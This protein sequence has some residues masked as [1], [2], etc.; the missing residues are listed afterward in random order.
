MTVRIAS[1]RKQRRYAVPKSHAACVEFEH[2][3]PNGQTYRLAITN[4]SASGLSFDVDEYAELQ[5]LEEGANVADATVRF[6]SCMIRGDLVVMHV[7]SEE[8]D[9]AICGA[10]IY[11]DSDTD[12]VKLK[13][14]IAGIE[15][16]ANDASDADD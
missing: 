7:S 4:V 6:G 8:G 2:P 14:V 13:S 15:A 16:I 1:R 12:L 5:Q 10:L 9:G 11:P 3:S